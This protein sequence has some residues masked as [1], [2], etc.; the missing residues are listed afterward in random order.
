MLSEV[1]SYARY[2]AKYAIIAVCGQVT[3]QGQPFIAAQPIIYGSQGYTHDTIVEVIDHIT[4]N[5]TDIASIVTDKYKH[6]DIDA[7]LKQA[8]SGKV[9][10][11]ITDYEI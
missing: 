11:V 10:K 3:L 5:K 2:R 7:A 6:S 9:I 8:A 4:H 1:F